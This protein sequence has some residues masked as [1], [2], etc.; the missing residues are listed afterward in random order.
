MQV[1]LIP[2]MIWGKKRWSLEYTDKRLP[3][4]LV[5]PFCQHCIWVA[6]PQDILPSH[7]GELAS[8]E[9]VS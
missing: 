2:L 6:S 8:T 3:F 9:I 7:S 4:H 5:L 1:L